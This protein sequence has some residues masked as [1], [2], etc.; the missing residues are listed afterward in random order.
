[1]HEH[2]LTVLYRKVLKDT[3]LPHLRSSLQQAGVEATVIEGGAGERH[4][5]HHGLAR[6]EPMSWLP[7]WMP[8]TDDSSVDGGYGQFSTCC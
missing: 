8:L 5:E 2:K 3:L 7:V 4:G 6:Q 1:M